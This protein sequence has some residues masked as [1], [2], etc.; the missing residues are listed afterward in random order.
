LDT[1]RLAQRLAGATRFKTVSYR[2]ST[3]FHAREFT[4]SQAY[5]RATSPRVH[6]ALKLEKVNGYGLLYEWTGSD[7]NL[8]PIILRAH[9]AVVPVEPGTES[10]WTEPP[11]EGRIAGGYVWGRGALD[12][13]GSLVG[14]LEAVEHLVAAGA[15]PPRTAYLAFGY[16]EEVGRRR[17]A[18][19]I[20]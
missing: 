9:Q 20:A 11:F 15:Q 7:P 16:H 4:G 14:I 13:K 12:D 5:L 17:G 2:G 6:A 1:C 19:H 18:A 10:R 8:P 3:Q